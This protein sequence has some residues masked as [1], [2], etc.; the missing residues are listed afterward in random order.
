MIKINSS[1]KYLLFF[2][3]LITLIS[4]SE[5]SNSQEIRVDE[6]AA[7]IPTVGHVDTLCETQ[8]TIQNI[9]FHK[10][11]FCVVG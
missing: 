5:I 7:T 8:P 10:V 3:A 6:C 2:F 11:A 9:I 4:F 1:Y